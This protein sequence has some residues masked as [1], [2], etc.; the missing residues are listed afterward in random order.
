MP[1]SKR[2]RQRV[3]E[4]SRQLEKARKTLQREQE[5]ENRFPPPLSDIAE[6]PAHLKDDKL[7]FQEHHYEH[8][9]N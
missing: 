7:N 3:A 4:A 9:L 6:R 5:K 2:R 1:K 8:L